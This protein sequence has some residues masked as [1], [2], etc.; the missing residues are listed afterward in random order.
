MIP[1]LAGG[2]LAEGG[3]DLPVLAVDKG[4]DPLEEL[5]GPFGRD[6]DQREPVFTV[7]KTIFYGDSCHDELL[8]KV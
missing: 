2:D 1:D 3:H 5:A 7:I 6:M 4:V 8:M